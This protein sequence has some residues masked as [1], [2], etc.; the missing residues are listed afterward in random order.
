[1][2]GAALEGPDR[3]HAAQGRPGGA[4]RPKALAGSKLPRYGGVAVFEGGFAPLS[5]D[6]PDV[7]MRVISMIDLA[8]DAPMARR[9]VRHDGNWPLHPDAFACLAP[10]GSGGPCIAPRMG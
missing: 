1:M 5:I 4:Q 3:V 9:P 6:M 2:D 8:D 10:E 7:D